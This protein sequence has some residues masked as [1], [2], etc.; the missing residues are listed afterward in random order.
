MFFSVPTEGNCEI[1]KAKRSGLMFFP[2]SAL[3][4]KSMESADMYSRLIG[5]TS[6]YGLN[7]RFFLSGHV[8]ALM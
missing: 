6:K 5:A 4:V 3:Q 1:L 8:V 7:E 2:L